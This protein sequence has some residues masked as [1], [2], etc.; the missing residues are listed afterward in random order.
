MKKFTILIFTMVISTGVSFATKHTVTNSGTTFSPSNLTI[1]V[2]D[3]V[4]FSLSSSHD[5]VEVSKTTYDANGN[6]SNNGFKLLLGGGTHVFKTAGTYYYVCTPHAHLG[7]KGVITV[8]GATGVADISGD[9]QVLNVYPN[10]SSGFI[11][12]NYLLANKAKVN[13]QLLD[14]NG[15]VV[16][17]LLSKTEGA[18]LHEE[19]ISIQG[20]IKP[21]VYFINLQYG[22]ISRNK[23]II[24]K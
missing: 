3:T 21:G 16:K 6:T 4:V 15:R 8:T 12:V 19:T 20:T 24:I 17:T 1:N 14:A 9:F 10:P 23:K 18:G 5:A 7:M 22:E 11:K 2:N 13:I